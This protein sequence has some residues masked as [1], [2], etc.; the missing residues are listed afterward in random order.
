MPTMNHL[1][2]H[3]DT[4]ARHEQEFQARRSKAERTADRITAFAGSFPFVLIHLGV[5]AGWMGTNLLPVGM[6]LRFDAAP[7]PLLDTVVALEA[8]LLASLILMR[9][10]GL[11]RRADE[12]EHLM[13]QILLLTEKEVSAVI[14]MNQEIARSL[15]LR[16]MGRDREIAE[17][18]KTTSVDE[19][20]QTI[21]EHLSG[22]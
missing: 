13:L 2:E 19:V 1:Q 7:F 5:F 10:T 20:A 11:A 8:I 16:E 6:G 17:L 9:Q 4:I 15:G 18:G 21:Q 12:R 14:R 22:E 3:I